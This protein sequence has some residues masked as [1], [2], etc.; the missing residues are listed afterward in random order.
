MGNVLSAGLGQ[1][2]ARQAALGAGLPDTIAAFSVNKV[3]GSGLKAV[4]LA[5]QAVRA[6]DADV[7][8]A[9]GM[10]SMSNAPYLLRGLRDGVK[11]TDQTI[12]DGMILDGLWCALED[13]HMG[14]SAEYTAEKSGITREEQDA[15]AL[16][17]HQKAVA[18]QDAGAFADEIVPV[19]VPQRRGDPLMVATD[20]TPRRETSLEKLARLRPV[21]KRDGGTVTAGNASSINDGAAAVVV[22]GAER[23]EGLGR[24]PLARIVGSCTAGVAPIDIFYAPIFAVRDV[25]E[26]AGLALD[27]IDVFELNEAFS[28]QAVADIRELRI[29]P[30]KVNVRGGAVALG[31]PIGASGARVLT[32]LLYVMKSEGLK[33]GVAAL[34][35][36]GGNAVAMLVER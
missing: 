30:E 18:A 15:F 33:R 12:Q 8:V 4:M 32:T 34:C 24:E 28:A 19:E 26:K 31:H 20:E 9:G 3:C 7:I 10:E 29:D 5:A 2:P 13:H 6:G 1:A 14:L 35:L 11:M 17:S 36:G 23:A 21:F 27:D 25:V 16:S 22:T